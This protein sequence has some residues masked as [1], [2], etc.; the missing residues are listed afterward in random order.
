M[1]FA[2]AVENEGLGFRVVGIGTF[3]SPLRHLGRED[4][5]VA[6][7]IDVAHIEGVTVDHVA[8]EQVVSFP[9]GFIEW[10]ADAFIPAQGT[11]T[12]AGRD[13]DLR[14]FASGD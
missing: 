4:V 11:R 13:D 1:A 3:F 8:L 12:V 5:Q 2:I 10:V 9:I 6:I 14:I 7:A